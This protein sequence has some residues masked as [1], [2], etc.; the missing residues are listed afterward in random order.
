MIKTAR[1]YLTTLSLVVASFAATAG[2]AL[3]ATGEGTLDI[4]K[5]A[6]QVLPGTPDN[7]SVDAPQAAFSSWIAKNLNI[8]F[9]VATLMVFLYLIWGAFEWISSSG[10]KGK[11]E[12]AR[13]R[14]MHA[15]MGLIVLAATVAIFIFIQSILH[16]CIVEFGTSCTQW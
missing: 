8:A 7:F 1:N 11:L 6:A 12:S 14:M 10:E 5:K 2:A 9:I 16:I 4:G 15:A 3:A 13:N